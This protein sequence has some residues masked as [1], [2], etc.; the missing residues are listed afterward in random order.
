MVCSRTQKPFHTNRSTVFVVYIISITPTIP[1]T[2]TIT[3]IPIA[4]IG[5]RMAGGNDAGTIEYVIRNSVGL[6]STAVNEI[7]CVDI[8]IVT[9]PGQMKIKKQSRFARPSP[10]FH[11][12]ARVSTS[13]SQTLPTLSVSSILPHEHDACKF[14]YRRNNPCH[15]RGIEHA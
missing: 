1:K 10:Q 7:R 13:L 5:E 9:A 3:T 8:R 15:I 4:A 2:A 12:D 14:G 6:G 11:G